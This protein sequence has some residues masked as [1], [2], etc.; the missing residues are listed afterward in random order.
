[1]W[2]QRAD[3]EK[4]REVGHGVESLIV[5]PAES[6]LTG[7]LP[8]VSARIPADVD[9]GVVGGIPGPAAADRRRVQDTVDSD[10]RAKCGDTPV[11]QARTARRDYLVVRATPK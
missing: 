7:H 6:G 3:V 5:G 11:A 2:V 8:V 10:Q 4:A 9:G 1:M